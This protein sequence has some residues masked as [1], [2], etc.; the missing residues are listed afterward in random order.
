MYV[1]ITG[2]SS[3][4]G[5]EL[6]KLYAKAKYD[7]VLVARNK[8]RL[9]HLASELKS[10]N[11]DVIVK[12][13]DLSDLAQC[14]LLFDEIKSLDINIFINNAGYGNLGFFNETQEDLE[15]NMLDL[16]IRAVQ[17]LTKRYI[18][19]YSTGTVVNISSMA[20]FLPTPTFATYAAT[21]S[22]VYN[23]SRAVNYELK[24]QKSNLRVL[25]VAP[26]PVKTNFNQRAKASINRGMDQVKC[27]R[28]IWKGIQKRKDFIIPGFLMKMVYLM[29]KFTPTK[30]LLKA[31]YR[32]QTN[33]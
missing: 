12:P 29:T 9:D 20:A 18:Q 33:K 23:M 30:L 22:Y 11:I 26:G 1:L 15:L 21:K 27:A 5:M 2:A 24:R 10:E 32:I 25:T 3:G 31:S 6:A 13:F 7:L 16:N 14:D 4:I 19:H 17:V 28:L 8:D